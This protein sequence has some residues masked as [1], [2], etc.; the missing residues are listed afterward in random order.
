M[1]CWTRAQTHGAF[2]VIAERLVKELLELS[3]LRETIYSMSMRETY[4]VVVEQV[5]CGG[6]SEVDKRGHVDKSQLGS[7]NTAALPRRRYTDG[8]VRRV[9]GCTVAAASRRRRLMSLLTMLLLLLDSICDLRMIGV[10]RRHRPTT[11]DS[12]R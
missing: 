4:G 11:S 8:Q 1:K 9:P 7:G 10:R 5:G 6:E 2:S 3:G 12:C